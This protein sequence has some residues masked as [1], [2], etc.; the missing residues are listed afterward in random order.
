LTLSPRRQTALYAVLLF[1]AGL[2]YRATFLAQG[3]NA[4]D[5]AFIPALATRVLNGQVIYR[6]FVYASPPLTVFKEVGVAALLGSNYGYLASRWVFAIEV[7]VASVIAYLIIRRY[8]PLLVAFLVTLPSVFFTTILYQYSNFNFDAQVLFLIG[9]LLVVWDGERER[10]VVILMAGALCGMAFLAK[11]T[12]L[13]MAVGICG[14]GLLRPLTGGPRR[15]PFFA[16]G[17]AIVVGIVFA[18]IWAAGLWAEF[19]HQAFG[20]LF[21]ANPRPK[22]FYLVQDWPKY[23]LPPG[24]S[25]LPV[26]AAAVLLVLARLRSWAAVPAIVLLGVL[27]AALIVPAVPSSTLGTPNNNQRY[28]LVGGLALI[29]AINLVASAVTVAARLPGI[30]SRPWASSVRTELFPP[31][32]PIV[33]AVLEY[34]HGIDLSTML[35]A[36][37]G[38]FLGIPVALTFLYV[39]W[40]LWS[41]PALLNVAVP[42]VVGAFLVVAGAVITYAS[43][44]LDGP[45]DQ[46]TATFAAPRLA[47]ISTVP[48][49]AAH[50]DGLVAE[51]ERDTKPGDRVF[52]FPDGQAYYVIA[53]RV[54]PTHVDW[55]NLLSTTPAISLQAL[56][57]LKLKPPQYVFV[58]EYREAD[59]F[60]RCPLVPDLAALQVRHLGSCSRP[61]DREPAWSPIYDFI[62]TAYDLV[63]TVDGVRVYHLR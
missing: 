43:P 22:A 47:G 62:T 63:T 29:L 45:R 4:S 18:A 7:S 28:L 31:M 40:R 25:G 37:A 51:I 33:A 53:G 35:F 15:W 41:G 23:V 59:I 54:N 21:T 36:Y 50:V 61:Y 27:L 30:A 12:Y 8:T 34:M 26:L 20:L 1:A 39:G 56:D 17:F 42:A 3:F 48:A 58:Q 5:E 24:R 55:Y 9:F 19:R 6:D 13:A 2:L 44:Y 10:A 57:D 49:N 60:H 16:A 46:M 52:I 14:L 32:V 11:P 38:T